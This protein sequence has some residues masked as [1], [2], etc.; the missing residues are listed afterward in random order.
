MSIR[1]NGGRSFK[2]NLKNF[3]NLVDCSTASLLPLGDSLYGFRS[4]SHVDRFTVRK[5]TEATH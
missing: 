1:E 4:A 2:E 5:E 3:A